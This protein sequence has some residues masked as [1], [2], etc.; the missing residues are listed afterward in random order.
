MSNIDWVKAVEQY[1][2]KNPESSL[3]HHEVEAHLRNEYERALE[4][5]MS[6]IE[7]IYKFFADYPETGGLHPDGAKFAAY[8]SFEDD[9]DTKTAWANGET[10]GDAIRQLYDELEKEKVGK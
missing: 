3:D 5:K 4:V 8:A 9:M 10:I 6:E 7:L 2:S 1:Y